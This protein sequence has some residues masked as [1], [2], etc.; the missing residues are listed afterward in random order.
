M[1]ID[2]VYNFFGIGMFTE[3]LARKVGLLLGKFLAKIQAKIGAIPSSPLTTDRVSSHAPRE[4][5]NQWPPLLYG[6][7]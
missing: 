6:K 2:G 5:K 3:A 7:S 1:L 4:T